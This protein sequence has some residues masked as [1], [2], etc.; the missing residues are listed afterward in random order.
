VLMLLPGQ[1][2]NLE[3][4]HKTKPTLI[5]SETEKAVAAWVYK[6]G[7][8]AGRSTNTLSSAKWYY[9]PLKT[10]DNTLGVVCVMKLDIEKNF[11]QEQKRLLESFA[12]VVAL[13]ITKATNK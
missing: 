1:T 11:T 12:S 8:P 4:V 5:L 9:V 2:E 7:S 10:Q 13:A 6:N 3:L